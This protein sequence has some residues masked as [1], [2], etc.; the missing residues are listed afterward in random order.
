VHRIKKD[1]L[2]IIDGSYLLYRSFY[3]IRS[4]NTST[5]EP[6]QAVFGFCRAMKKLF[7]V[8][9]PNYLV[10][11]WD[12][13]GKNF[14]HE[15]FEGYKATRD[16]APNDLF[17]Q[18]VHIVNYLDAIGVYQTE[19]KGYE[20]DDVI[21]SIAQQYAS[22]QVILVCADKDMYQ[23]LSP[24]LLIFDPF[25]D[26][27]I[28][29]KDFKNETG[30]G[31][32]KI[33]F[34]Y[35]LLGDAAD[36]IP[37]V[38]GI[39][40]KG[41]EKLVKQFNSLE[42]MY[43]N[44]DRV[45]K[46]RTKKLLLENKD[47][48]FLSRTLFLLRPPEMSIPLDKMA[49]D[50]NNL[51]HAKPLFRKLMFRSL[52]SDL[53]K[54]FPEKQVVIKSDGFQQTSIFGSAGSEIQALGPSKCE[55]E[56]IIVRDENTLNELINLLKKKKCFA[57][58]TETTGV[59]PLQDDL[60]GMSFAVDDKA[61]YYI[62]VAHVDNQQLEKQMVLEKLRP[63]F[64]DKNIAS[65]MHAA[66]FDQL[67]IKNN[68]IDMP[69][70][71]FDTL[72]SAN[73]L[74][75]AWQKKINLKDLS[76]MYLNEPM[77]TYKQV[78]GKKYKN[79]G[80]VPVHEGAEY[81]AHD[82]LQ[83]YKLY[84]LF[85]S[86]LKKEKRLQKIF[87]DIEMPFYRVLMRMEEKGIAVDQ[88]YLEKIL[89]A[90]TKELGA[91]ESKIYAAIHVKRPDITRKLNLRSSLQVAKLL[92]DD[93]GLAPIKKSAKGSRSTDQ[94]VLEKLAEVHPVPGMIITHRELSKLKNTY[95]EPIPTYINPKTNRIHTSY[96][97]T[98]VATGRLASSD[99]NLQN[100]PTGEGYGMQ[101]REAFVAPPDNIFMSADYSQVEIRI[102]AH[103]TQDPKL[104][105]TFKKGIDIHIQTASQLFDVSINNVSHDQRQV[106]KRINFSIMYGISPFGLAKDL[107]IK[108]G[109]AK[110]YI[111]K[112]FEQYPKVAS[113][114][115]SVIQEAKKR[116]YVETLMG[117]RRYIPELQERNKNLFESG[118]RMAINTPVQGTQAEIMKI[119]MIRIDQEFIKK[120][121][122]ARIIL[123][124]H[125]EIVLEL[126][127]NE[128]IEVVK[129][130]KKH[131][132]NVVKWQVPLE[133]TT[134]IGHNWGQ[135]TK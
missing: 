4:L 64:E 92:F 7:D 77:V 85:S 44:L 96:N 41:A 13:K 24:T 12:A 55:W 15:I 72:L 39:G 90:V 108:Q 57:F 102:L 46:E 34:Y 124:I 121:L 69:P 62:P 33:P 99:P 10:V 82:A 95:L 37:G 63:I 2:F 20:A 8:F 130:V 120:G 107:N 105:E 66:K 74:R 58:D 23:L 86:D 87:D 110:S 65:I 35:S 59:R 21:A 133:V 52:L 97:Q 53:E 80:Q 42:D 115:E 30:F 45:E 123:Q 91:I 48:A 128:Q 122:L 78:V 119:A 135:I 88:A 71:L 127:K 75:A 100:I 22:K 106:G 76:Q 112:Y 111:E 83:T 70:V 51:R 18:K 16:A 104:L 17:E 47:N 98:M 49:F 73:L 1:A 68:G 56:L 11:V 129:I 43:D 60:V 61:A 93:L 132:E 126:P 31:S 117:R 6:V 134:R 114:M 19:K 81:A 40:K 79:F 25:K 131:M 118:R 109:D 54:R 14:R 89:N 125:D 27:L 94:E 38:R 9:D 26:K 36:N 84:K 3:A 28:D 101:I 113:W 67:V 29:Q 32:E 50:E 5:G 116:G 103:L